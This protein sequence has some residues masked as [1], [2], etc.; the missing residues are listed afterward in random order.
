MATRSLAQIF[1]GGFYLRHSNTVL[2]MAS[3]R[4]SSNHANVSRPFSYAKTA[5]ASH[6]ITKTYSHT[7]WCRLYPVDLASFLAG[8]RR[9]SLLNR[10]WHHLPQ[11]FDMVCPKLYF[12]D[13]PFCRYLH[14]G[15]R[16][17]FGLHCF[18]HA[19]RALSLPSC[20]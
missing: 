17:L 18:T 12:W 3:C 1:G 4:V 13:F 7:Y 15:T 6:P 9:C 8:A 2:E 5:F 11:G 10:F 16:L 20:I 14:F 19:N